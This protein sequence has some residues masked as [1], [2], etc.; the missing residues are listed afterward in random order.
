[1]KAL[2]AGLSDST[3]TALNLV[4][5]TS[6]C[7]LLTRI[8]FQ[9]LNISVDAAV[10]SRSYDMELGTLHADL[11]FETLELWVRSCAH[12]D[13]PAWCSAHSYLAVST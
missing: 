2:I 5:A 1:M 4:S 10:T 7:T 8:G 3:V 12:V 13:R 9:H 6:P 11:N